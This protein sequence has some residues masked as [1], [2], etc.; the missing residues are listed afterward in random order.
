MEKFIVDYPIVVL[1]LFGFGI[2]C[3]AWI[4]KTYF[5]RIMGRFD[6]Q[7]KM[8]VDVVREHAELKG[9]VGALEKATWGS[10]GD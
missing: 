10:H 1:L 6:A 5:D 2:S 9:R 7:D 8:L 3:L 4:G